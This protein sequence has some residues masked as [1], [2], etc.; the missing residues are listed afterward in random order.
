VAAAGK[1]RHKGIEGF[2][3][4]DEN[5]DQHIPG[6]IMVYGYYET[7]SR[8]GWCVLVAKV[9]AVT[10]VERAKVDVFLTRNVL[11]QRRGR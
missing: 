1:E 11:L 8:S 10:V 5:R 3:E 6:I 2:Y 7:S 9:R 4:M